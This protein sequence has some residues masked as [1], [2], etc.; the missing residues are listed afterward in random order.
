MTRAL[1]VASAVASGLLAACG[2]TP[3]GT[4]N[5]T[6]CGGCCDSDGFCQQGTSQA[7]CGVGGAICSPCNAMQMCMAGQCVVASNAG[8]SGAAGGTGTTAGGTGATAGGNLAGG[9]GATAGGS[10]ATAGGNT[11]GGTGATAGGNTAGGTGAT[12]GGTGATAGGNTAGGNAAGG[13]GATAGGNTAGGASAGGSTAGGSAG[14]PE[15]TIPQAKATAPCLQRVR[16][17]GVVVTGVDD[18]DTSGANILARFWVADPAN[19]A[20]TMFVEKFYQDPPVAYVPVVGDLLDVEGYMHQMSARQERIGYRPVFKNQF[21][22]PG[23][24]TNGNITITVVGTTTPP[25][26]FTTFSGFGN[27][28]GGTAKPNPTQASRRVHIPGPLTLTQAAPPAMRTSP[29]TS[30]R[31]YEVTGGI[32]VADY[33][34][35]RA[36]GGCAWRDVATAGGTVTFP[37]GI[38]GVW[39]TYTH[40]PCYD[41][42]TNCS[43]SV[44]A[45]DA[46]FVPSTNN[47]FTYVLFPQSCNDVPAT[48]SP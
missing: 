30:G 47:D 9:T 3:K 27:A 41:G 1:L 19:P 10:G 35:F 11:A 23:G 13:T 28:Q 37:N 15:M 16:V 44:S 5:P 45:R 29:P 32:L 40:A 33:R 12:A 6:Q 46:G 43:L 34:T 39:D 25:A 21:N 42:T 38:D 22:C 17:R 18:L 7:E 31:G 2:T 20:S 26:S 48:V 24:P 8:G 14:I 36:D 4:C